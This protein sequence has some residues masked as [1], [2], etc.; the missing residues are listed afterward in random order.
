[1]L[2]II[3]LSVVW[4][5]ALGRI[6]GCVARSITSIPWSNTGQSPKVFKN[7][8]VGISILPATF[9]DREVDVRSEPVYEQASFLSYSTTP[10]SCYIAFY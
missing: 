4:I 10:F 1:M 2:L 7:I 3:E 9:S 6:S 5:S 8:S